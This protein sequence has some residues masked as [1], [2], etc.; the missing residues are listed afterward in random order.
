MARDSNLLDEQYA[1]ERERLPWLVH[2]DSRIATA[3]SDGDISPCSTAERGLG[4]YIKST[5]SWSRILSELIVTTSYRELVSGRIPQDHRQPFTSIGVISS[6]TCLL[7]S[8][9]TPFRILISSSRR[10]SS[11][12]LWNAKKDLAQSALSG[13][14]KAPATEARR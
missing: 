1:D 11:P 6:S 4:S 13:T 2:R 12:C 8:S 10:G 7:F 3:E 9:K 5:V 14:A